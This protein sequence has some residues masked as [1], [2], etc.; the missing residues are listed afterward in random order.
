MV[1]HEQGAAFMADVY[2]RLTGKPSV[3]LATLGPGATNL[4]TGIADAFQD[5]SP[6]VV[7]T[8]QGGLPRLHKESHQVID[9]TRIYQNITKWSGRIVQPKSIPEMVRKAFK[10]AK[11]QKPGPTLLELPEDLAALE[12]GEEQPLLKR[13]VPDRSVPSADAIERAAQTIRN[14]KKPV[15]IV[16]NGVVRPS[17]HANSKSQ[18]GD[19]SAAEALRKLV[20]QTHIPVITTFMGKGAISDREPESLLTLGLGAS[21]QVFEVLKAADLA[22]CVGYDIVEYGPEKWNKTNLPI[23]HIDYEP[24]EVYAAYTPAVELIGDVQ[25][26]LEMLTPHL[27]NVTVDFPEAKAYRA[28]IETRW[29]RVKSETKTLA[30]EYI[31]HVLRDLLHDDDIIISDVGAHKMWIG[32]QFPAYVPNTVQISNGF[33]PMGFALPG[34]IG[35]KLA[36]PD[37]RVVSINGDGGVLMNIQDLETAKRLGL[38]FPVIIFNDFAYSLIEEKFRNENAVTDPLKITNPDFEE[39][40]KAFGLQGVTVKTMEELKPALEFALHCDTVCLV[41]IHID[42]EANQ[43]LFRG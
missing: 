29:K 23:V 7:V 14:A 28:A 9:I 21:K 25:A 16:G 35:A 37:R 17:G 2:G 19:V 36:M 32:S 34:A 43:G 18:E 39:L 41:N 4:M 15:L 27:K 31:L 8:G 42:T 38:A 3:C 26:S 30:P 40:A 11:M 24:A 33:C 1:R 20:A 5:R 12:M 10:V 6:V 22:I 13:T